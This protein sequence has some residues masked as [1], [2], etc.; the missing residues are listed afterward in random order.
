[1]VIWCDMVCLALALAPSCAALHFWCLYIMLSKSY[2]PRRC[3]WKDGVFINPHI[4]ISTQ[5]TS[6]WRSES[7]QKTPAAWLTVTRSCAYN[8]EKKLQALVTK[9][10]ASITHQHWN[11]SS[12]ILKILCPFGIFVVGVGLKPPKEPGTPRPSK[13]QKPVSKS[14]AFQNYLGPPMGF[15][16]TRLKCSLVNLQ[17]SEV[18]LPCMKHHETM[19]V[20]RNISNLTPP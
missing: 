16:K 10:V 7:I 13:M 1:M 9:S 3:D 15:R 19:T 8:Y 11:L 18:L 14:W 12:K 5:F 2:L 6:A 4:F 20:C 17:A